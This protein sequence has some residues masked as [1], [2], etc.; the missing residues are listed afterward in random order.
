MVPNQYQWDK[1][2]IDKRLVFLAA[3]GALLTIPEP[4][5]TVVL[6][7]LDIEAELNRAG[8]D[9]L[10][11]LSVPPR[12]MAL[13]ETLAY[14]IDAR[15]SRGNVKY[16]LESGP[17]GM[18]VSDDGLVGWAP[19]SLPPDGAVTAV[20]SV[21][22]GARETKHALTIEVRPP[23]DISAEAETGPPPG[24]WSPEKPPAK[25]AGNLVVKLPGKYDDVAPAAAADSSFLALRRC[26]SWLYSTCGPRG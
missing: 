8:K 21:A 2:A 7:P 23:A 1:L 14:Q 3:A 17:E 25:P 22:D 12:S 26:K 13:G 19:A 10:M 24:A 16:K 20:V 9:F 18:T 4:R 15:S 6:R 11:V 5:D